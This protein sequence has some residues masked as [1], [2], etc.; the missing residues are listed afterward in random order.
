[1]VEKLKVSEYFPSFLHSFRQNISF[2][3]QTVQFYQEEEKLSCSAFD[4]KK[5]FTYQP[6]WFFGSSVY[7]FIWSNSQIYQASVL[8]VVVVLS[9]LSPIGGLFLNDSDW[10]A[11]CHFQ[12][13]SITGC[14]IYLYSYANVV[15]GW[16]YSFWHL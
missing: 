6:V 2:C 11:I 12:S 3:M 4:R 15:F 1:M 13:V 14:F 9:P 5:V 8:K 10:W 7:D 16:S